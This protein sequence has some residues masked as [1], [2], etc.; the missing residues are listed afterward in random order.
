MVSEAKNESRLILK[1]A[2]VK[3][4]RRGLSCA[5]LGVRK[6]SCREGGRGRRGRGME[7]GGIQTRHGRWAPR[8]EQGR[9]SK[10]FVAW[11]DGL[12]LV[13]CCLL[14]ER[15]GGLMVVARRQTA[16]DGPA[17]FE[18]RSPSFP[19]RLPSSRNLVFS[20]FPLPLPSPPRSSAVASE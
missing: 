20:W 1:V 4:L 12:S 15:G 5:G 6:A 7:L 17:S 9:S 2:S 13:P 8:N 14:H 10:S 3:L 11:H 19:S 16:E 18:S